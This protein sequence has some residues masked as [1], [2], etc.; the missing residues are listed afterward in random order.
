MEKVNDVET[1]KTGVK[2][3]EL[4]LLLFG[5][6]TTTLCWLR[7]KTETVEV[8]D[9]FKALQECLEELEI[10]SA[11]KS[12]GGDSSGACLPR[13]RRGPFPV[14]GSGGETRGGNGLG[15]KDLDASPASVL[16]VMLTQQS[17]LMEAGA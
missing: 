5:D 12:K 9:P 2:S 7:S 17:C 8:A 3:C 16:L 1:A 15:A 14:W 10:G 13:G 6:H 4:W 11:I